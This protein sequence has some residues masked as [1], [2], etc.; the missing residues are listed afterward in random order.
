MPKLHMIEEL[1]RVLIEGYNE[2]K[3]ELNSYDEGWAQIYSAKQ[4]D[5]IL[6]ADMVGVEV[7]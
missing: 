2:A 6:Q 4:N 3:L 7:K 1:K 5:L